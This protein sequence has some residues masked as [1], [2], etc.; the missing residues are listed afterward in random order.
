VGRNSTLPYADASFDYILAS[1]S[2]FYLD[3]ED[4]FAANLAEISRVMRPGAVFVGTVPMISNQYFAESE[5]LGGGIRRI[6]R[7][8]LGLREGARLMSFENERRVSSEFDRYFAEVRIGEW[9]ND[10][11]G[12]REHMFLVVA[13]CSAAPDGADST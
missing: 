3:A 8:E 4:D 2:C 12:I 9:K 11:W 6:T 1:H 5:D 7:D 10:F 13:L